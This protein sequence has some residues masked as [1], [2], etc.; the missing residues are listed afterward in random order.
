[1]ILSSD[2]GRLGFR[3]IFDVGIRDSIGSIHGRRWKGEFGYRTWA[4]CRG[5]EC[6]LI[7]FSSSHGRLFGR[8]LDQVIHIKR[9]HKP[10]K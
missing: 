7:L 1:M 2:R 8:A 5:L 3:R 10:E 4:G 6:P 9:T